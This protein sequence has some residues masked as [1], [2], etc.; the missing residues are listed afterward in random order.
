[1]KNTIEDFRVSLDNIDNAI[2]FLLAERFHITK[3]VGEYKKIH[4]LPAQDLARETSQ[5]KRIKKLAK[6]AG[7]NGMFA[8]KIFRLIIDEVISNH[9]G[10]SSQ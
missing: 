8:T 6:Q 3:K 2:I 1:M 7:L 5:F 9:K 4:N 10:T